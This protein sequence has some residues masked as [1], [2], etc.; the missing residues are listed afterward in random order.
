MKFDTKLI[1]GG[2]SEDP[3]TGAVSMPIYRA[4]T[5]HQKVLGDRKSG[6]QG[7]SVD[8]GGCRII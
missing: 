1:H 7:R 6:V 3:T 8:L 2:M 4:S 5:F